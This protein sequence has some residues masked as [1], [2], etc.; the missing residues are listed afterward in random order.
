MRKKSRETRPLIAQVAKMIEL[1]DYLN[2]YPIHFLTTKLDII[3]GDVITK[4]EFCLA[5]F[6]LI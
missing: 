3:S 5:V 1:I 4:Y 6:I 2:E